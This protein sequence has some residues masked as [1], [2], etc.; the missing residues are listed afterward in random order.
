MFWRSALCLPLDAP[1]RIRTDLA[2]AQ[3]PPS[4]LKMVGVRAHSET[5]LCHRN[6][7]DCQKQCRKN[8]MA[9]FHRTTSFELGKNVAGRRGVP[10]RL[11]EW[12]GLRAQDGRG[13]V[14][15]CRHRRCSY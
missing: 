5:L 1:A 6:G 10:T 13:V 11:R 4:L 7:W 9:E 14:A 8:E 3:C 12:P 2:P 15:G